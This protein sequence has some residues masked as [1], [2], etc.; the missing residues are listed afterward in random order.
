M[1]GVSVLKVIGE[2]VGAQ[3]PEEKVLPVPEV[4]D[5]QPQL[6]DELF[7]IRHGRLLP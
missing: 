5:V 6:T 1:T 2:N 3:F 7:W 4:G